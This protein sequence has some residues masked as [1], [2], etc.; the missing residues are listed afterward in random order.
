MLV[1]IEMAPVYADGV[2]EE[3]VDAEDNEDGVSIYRIM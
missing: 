2:E 3:Y 1:A